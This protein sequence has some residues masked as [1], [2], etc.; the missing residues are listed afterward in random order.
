MIK[1]ITTTKLQLWI[2]LAKL[3]RTVHRM[4]HDW[5]MDSSQ[6]W[7]T[8]LLQLT[9]STPTKNNG[10]SKI[11]LTLFCLPTFHTWWNLGA[12]SSPGPS[13]PAGTFCAVL[14]GRSSARPPLAAPSAGAPVSMSSPP[15]S[16]ASCSVCSPLPLDTYAKDLQHSEDNFLSIRQKHGYHHSSAVLSRFHAVSWTKS[17]MEE[18][19]M[20]Q[21]QQSKGTKSG[22]CWV[23]VPYFQLFQ[24]DPWRSDPSWTTHP[25]KGHQIL[26]FPRLGPMTRD[27]DVRDA[28]NV[29]SFL[30]P[31]KLRPPAPGGLTHHHG[32]RR[33]VPRDRPVLGRVKR[34][35]SKVSV[36]PCH[37][38]RRA[39]VLELGR[40]PRVWPAQESLAL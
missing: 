27:G 16:P 7:S 3:N 6:T 9:K 22:W 39:K 13:T 32:G 34:L 14:L 24:G 19:Q 30:P 17:G 38:R 31:H 23:Q 11:F 25:N 26:T 33:G 2:I 20:S 36:A 21:S 15:A 1:I 18:E 29:V 4:K 8:D 35:V 28:H 10:T 40:R 5:S 37:A 12:S